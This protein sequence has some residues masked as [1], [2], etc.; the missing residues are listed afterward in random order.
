MVVIG[1]TQLIHANVQLIEVPFMNGVK[2]GIGRKYDKD[3][4]FIGQCVYK[5]GR[6]VR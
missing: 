6:L 5:D 1:R 3:G 4:S 2:D